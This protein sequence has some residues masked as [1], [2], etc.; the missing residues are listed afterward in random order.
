MVRSSWI[1]LGG[2]LLLLSGSLRAERPE[3]EQLI[4]RATRA[5]EGLDYD[6][7]SDLWIEVIAHPASTEEQRIVAN[8]RAGSVARIRDKD[9]EARM[10]YVYVLERIPDYT[11]PDQTSPRIRNF[12]ELVR[13]EVRSRLEREESGAQERA[14]ETPPPPPSPVEPEPRGGAAAPTDEAP[15]DSPSLLLISGAAAVG[16]GAVL[17]AIG[18]VAGWSAQQAHE[19]A[20]EADVQRDRNLHYDDRDQFSLVA[21]V[22][23]GAAALMVA[24][25]AAAAG[26]A[27]VPGDD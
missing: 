9:V 20:L 16:V 15:D 21:N 23:Y 2:A 10:H 25:G 14:A 18:G 7:A 24:A 13:Q 19:S 17:G 5:E 22:C 6:R 27:L 26:L 11:L 1:I 3:V 12:F 8:F 4:E